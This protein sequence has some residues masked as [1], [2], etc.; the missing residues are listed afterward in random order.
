MPAQFL[1]QHQR[2]S[3][4][5]YTVPPSPEELA[6]FFHLNDNDLSL[7]V[8]KRGN[9]NKLGFAL[10]LGTVRFLGIFLANPVDVPFPILRAVAAQLEISDFGSLKKYRKGEQKWK[11]ATEI[12]VHYHYLEI[13]DPKISFKL[14]RWLCALCWT[15]TDRPSV[16][17]DHAKT[18]LLAHKILL[19]GVSIL[20]RLIVRIRIRMENRLWR[21][22]IREVAPAQKKML[23][24]LLVVPTHSRN[25]LLDQL[26][27]GPV[28]TSAP[29][30]VKAIARLQEVRS[31]EI[32][33][34]TSKI[35]H[36]RL[37]S[38]ARLASTAKVTA[39][40]RLP[41]THR[42]A[43]LVAFVH[44]LEATANDDVLD[45]LNMLLKE[46]FGSARKEN[47][48]RRLRTLKDLDH[49]AI[50]W[51]DAGQILLDTSFPDRNLRSRIFNRIPRKILEQAA[52]DIRSLVQPP[53]DIYFKDW[54][55]TIGA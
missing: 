27:S 39:I 11:H 49:A 42:Q 9:H 34:P 2:E 5:R 44:C 15:G 31:L 22:L 54:Q 43:V 12:R 23:E 46:L 20:E 47:K 26:R 10:Q 24:N 35:P 36:V 8:R 38:L 32:K 50:L 19:P 25:S 29:A 41:K 1:T 16:L 4:G 55:R 48:K 21:F 37:S 40:A 28:R 30:L 7:I 6:R 33:L 17:F 14:N 52:Q 3:Y 53:D 13:S 45:V 51:A 18:W